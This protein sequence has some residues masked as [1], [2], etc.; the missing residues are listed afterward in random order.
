VA[1][2]ST[3]LDAFYQGTDGVLHNA[4]WDIRYGWKNQTLSGGAGGSPSAVARAPTHWDV[5]YRSSAGHLQNEFWDAAYGWRNVDL[6]VGIAGDPHVLAKK[7]T[8]MHAYGCVLSRHRRRSSQCVLGYQL[9]L[10]AQDALEA[11]GKEA[12]MIRPRLAGMAVATVLVAAQLGRAAPASA[13]SS[14]TV[15]PSANLSKVSG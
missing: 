11:Q 15:T 6:G 5:M 14:V 12:V 13:A 2:T 8:H 7:S 3:H 9:R 4:F 1:D 10:E